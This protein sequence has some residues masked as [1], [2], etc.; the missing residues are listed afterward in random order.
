MKNRKKLII[1]PSHIVRFKNFIETYCPNLDSFEF[2]AVG[3]LPIWHPVIQDFIKHKER[4]FSEIIILVGDFRFGNQICSD[5][6]HTLVGVPQQNKYLG[7]EKKNLNFEN[8][9]FMYELS[10]NALQVLSG[11]KKIK[12]IFWDLFFREILNYK[13]VKYL[14]G[15]KYKHPIWNYKSDS[16]LFGNVISLMPLYDYDCE[17]LVIDSSLHPSILGFYFLLCLF[18]GND[19]ELSLL[20]TLKF[21][22]FFNKKIIFRNEYIICGDGV[23]FRTLKFYLSIGAI[24]LPNKLCLS[25]ADDALFTKRTCKE[26]LIFFSENFSNNEKYQK[27]KIFVSHAKYKSKVIRDSSIPLG[28]K[29]FLSEITHSTPNLVFLIHL[30]SNIEVERPLCLLIEETINYIKTS[31]YK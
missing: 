9:K 28:Q 26:N 5:A 23:F 6:S 24:C 1:G 7:I 29:R 17:F 20:K 16:S 10:L 27:T 3:G 21:R 22:A 2:K 30:V 19:S 14:S 12:L 25:R 4:D 31:F 15:N 11:N 8:D 18:L 13:N